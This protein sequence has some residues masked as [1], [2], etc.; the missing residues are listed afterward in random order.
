MAI[1][2]DPH[3]FTMVWVLFNLFL[4]SRELILVRVELLDT[5]IV[6]GKNT[7]LILTGN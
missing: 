5:K 4:L 2:R 1:V 7:D 3:G 6:S